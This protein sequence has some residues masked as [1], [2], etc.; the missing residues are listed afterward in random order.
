MLNVNGVTHSSKQFVSSTRVQQASLDLDIN[1]FPL[2][3]AGRRQV[4]A[5]I[6]QG[7]EKSYSANISVTMPFLLAVNNGRLKAALGIRSASSKLFIEQYLPGP[8]EQHAA[9]L[10]ENVSREE[11]AEIGH[12]YSNAR[13]FTIPLFLLTA[14][15]LF[16][17]DFKYL[18]FAGTERVLAIIANAGIDITYLNA[19]DPAM[20]ESN[21]DDWGS[22]YDTNPQVVL[23]SLS[24]V[25]S[26]I[27]DHPVYD[28]LFKQLE[29]KIGKVC[30]QLEALKCS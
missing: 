1:T 23:V 7:F 9:L 22:Y 14:V 10:Q 26:V 27:A 25:M 28:R 20:L 2:R 19:A 30:G 5:F 3:S 13:K 17:L 29:K 18:V 8:I 4:E 6:K 16:C 24:G 21:S 15:S 12:L 11:I